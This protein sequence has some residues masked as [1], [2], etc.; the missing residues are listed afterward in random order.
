MCA[1]CILID[2]KSTHALLNDRIQD[3]N[4]QPAHN[5]LVQ[6]RY[7]LGTDGEDVNAG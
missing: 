1:E 4:V 5:R 7:S 3:I 2:W 6:S